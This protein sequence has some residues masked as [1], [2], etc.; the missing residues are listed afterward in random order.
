MTKY[1]FT[2]KLSDSF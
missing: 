1:Q 2:K